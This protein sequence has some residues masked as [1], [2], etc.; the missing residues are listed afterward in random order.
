M[1]V[2]SSAPAL[3]EHQQPYSL[4]RYYTCLFICYILRSQLGVETELRVVRSDPDPEWG[5]VIHKVMFFHRGQ[6]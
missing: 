5:S 6:F 4:L 2:V 1:S 3:W